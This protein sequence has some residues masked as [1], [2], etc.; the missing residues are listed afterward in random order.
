MKAAFGNWRTLVAASLG[1]QSNFSRKGRRILHLHETSK[2]LVPAEIA[3][4]FNCPT[5]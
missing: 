3:V 4:T 5:S 1:A 2:F